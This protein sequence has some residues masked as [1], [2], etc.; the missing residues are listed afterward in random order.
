MKQ[1][2][3]YPSKSIRQIIKMTAGLISWCITA[4]ALTACTPSTRLQP[5]NS[6]ASQADT[7]VQTSTQASTQAPVSGTLRLAYEPPADYDPL[8]AT[9]DS[10]KD[11]L[12]L[13]YQS[14]YRVDQ[15]NGL[16][17]QLC[18]EAV[19]QDQGLTLAV[20]LSEGMYFSD[21]QPVQA[22]DVAASYQHI[23][24]LTDSPYKDGLSNIASIEITG[25]KQLRIHLK[26]ADPWLCYALTFPV[27]PAAWVN[28]DRQAFPQG[29]G[30]YMMTELDQSG[31]MVLE[32]NPYHPESAAALVQTISV[33][34]YDSFTQAADAFESDQVDL[35]AVSEAN[36]RERRQ[37]LGIE[38]QTYAGSQLYYLDYNRKSGLF[39][40]DEAF[41][42]LKQLLLYQTEALQQTTWPDGSGNLGDMLA[43]FPYPFNADLVSDWP[44][45]RTDSLR[46]AFSALN[47]LGQQADIVSTASLIINRDL[48]SEEQLRL[49][50]GNDSVT[51]EPLAETLAAYLETCGIPV[52]V[53][54]LNDDDYAKAISEGDYDLALA[55]TQFS[56]SPAP[57]MMTLF[58]A[59]LP[60]VTA[61]SPSPAASTVAD[62]SGTAALTTAASAETD[63]S[64]AAENTAI[65]ETL[66][67][68]FAQAWSDWERYRDAG[69]YSPD[70]LDDATLQSILDQLTAYAPFTVLGSAREGLMISS[71]VQ[72][73]LSALAE[74]PYSDIS[75]VWIWSGT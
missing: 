46:Q 70:P 74:D 11:L 49:I 2:S 21:G 54:A 35:L 44:L 23:G 3:E 53:S 16:Q 71:R 43:L 34:A 22:A 19:W 25:D 57:D 69:Q 7:A 62:L 4:V 32:L 51:K 12:P 6:A 64:E 15:S 9:D 59:L 28:S 40:Q 73:S 65:E 75:E 52:S 1:T 50:V 18:V 68:G 56:A 38:V 48:A 24:E 14:L 61:V 5:L 47:G 55:E 41:Y 27:L 72:G 33:G 67:A 26:Q 45:A 17:G 60:A 39:S 30:L 29:S 58:T 37:R 42:A 13:L 36:Y 8:A 20:E 66:G 10:Y 31:N 63:L